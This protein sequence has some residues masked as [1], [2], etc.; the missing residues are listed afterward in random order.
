MARASKAFWGLSALALGGCQPE[1]AEWQQTDCRNYQTES[2][3]A[4]GV[5]TAPNGQSVVTVTPVVVSICIE[6][7]YSCVPGK[8]GSTDCGKFPSRSQP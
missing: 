5:G 3:I 8:D 1:H 6:P 2:T 7:V 4:T